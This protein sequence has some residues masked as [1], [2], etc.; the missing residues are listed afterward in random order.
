MARDQLFDRVIAAIRTA[1]PQQAGREETWLA[2]ELN[3][4][5]QT[6]HNWG[7]RGVPPR[8]HAD[9]A[10]ALGWSVEHLLGLEEAAP[11]YPW[12][13][14]PFI[15]RAQWQELSAEQRAVVAFKARQ[16]LEEVLHAA[17][18]VAIY[19]KQLRAG[20]K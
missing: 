9:I 4:S 19:E 8:R 2:A 14:A 3:T 13:L 18:P 20:R 16:A 7:L 5:V 10:K 17:E 15:S 11:P 6:V 1:H 12:P